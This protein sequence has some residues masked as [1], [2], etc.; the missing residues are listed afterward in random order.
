M[1]SCSHAHP[2]EQ[3]TMNMQV[4][5]YLSFSYQHQVSIIYIPFTLF[6][7]LR[8]QNTGIRFMMNLN[9]TINWHFK[10]K[11]SPSYWKQI[12]KPLNTKMDQEPYQWN[13]LI[14]KIYEIQFSCKIMHEFL[15]TLVRIRWLN[16]A[17]G[18]FWVF[19]VFIQSSWQKELGFTKDLLYCPT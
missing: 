17:K 16:I 8:L 19:W 6:Q 14:P 15:T 1:P 7:S 3:P 5:H 9:A 18:L 11:T 4:M 13:E 10:K 12:A 2:L